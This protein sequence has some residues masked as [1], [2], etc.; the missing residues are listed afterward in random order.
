M[1]TLVKD[2]ITEIRN[3]YFS[4]EQKIMKERNLLRLNSIVEI[5]H[6][7]LEINESKEIL[8]FFKNSTKFS[9]DELKSLESALDEDL[10]AQS[11]PSSEDSYV[12]ERV[13]KKLDNSAKAINRVRE[14]IFSDLIYKICNFPYTSLLTHILTFGFC[15]GYTLGANID[16]WSRGDAGDL[17]G[18]ANIIK[19]IL[20]LS[21]P[22]Y[23]IS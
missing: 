11:V 18:L 5:A 17:N 16:L 12:L 19:F 22:L 7:I 2:M 3:E 20:T 21:A 15:S 13:A 8:N 9:E 6:E 14:I 4:F 23:S 10:S 1:P